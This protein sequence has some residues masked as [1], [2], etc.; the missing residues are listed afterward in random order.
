MVKQNHINLLELKAV[1]Y[2]LKYFVAEIK[3]TEILLKIDN[4]TA[5]SYI[6]KM[7]SIQYPKLSPLSK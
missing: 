3:A 1:F 5:I 4:S 2:G 6:N 7:G